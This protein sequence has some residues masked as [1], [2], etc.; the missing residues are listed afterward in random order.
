MSFVALGEVPLGIVYATDARADSKV[1]IVDTFPENSHPPITC[2][3]AAIKGSRG[4]AGKFLEFLASPRA[5]DIWMKY[6][7]LEIK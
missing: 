7:F 1:R 2:P 6:G 3:G 4:D 5:R